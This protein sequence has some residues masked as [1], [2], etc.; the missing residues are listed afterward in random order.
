MDFVLRRGTRFSFQEECLKANA[1]NKQFS[2][3]DYLEFAV[4]PS[5]NMSDSDCARISWEGYHKKEYDIMMQGGIIFIC[6]YQ[7]KSH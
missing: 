2:V 7:I 4:F 6:S 1:L 3:K 5:C